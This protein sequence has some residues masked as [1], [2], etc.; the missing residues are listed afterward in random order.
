MLY[1]IRCSAC[2]A[3]SVPYICQCRLH[4]VIW[5]YIGILISLF[6]AEPC[7]TAGLLFHSHYLPG[8]ILLTLYSMVWDR[9][10]PSS[11]Q[12]PFYWPKLP[13]AFVSSTVFAIYKI[14]NIFRFLALI[15]ASVVGIV[16][17]WSSDWY[18]VNRSF[19]AM[20]CPPFLII[21]IIYNILCI[22]T[23][24]LEIHLIS[25]PTLDKGGN[26]IHSF[27]TSV[28]RVFMLSTTG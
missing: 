12:L 7:S 13:A 20:H 1:Q 18:G 5:S 21:I 26:N 6:A 8:T 9:W 16:G 10:V 15:S 4:A 14:I 27:K 22:L 19:L 2:G 28:R 24:L 23:L 11:G 25:Q 3:K 17:L